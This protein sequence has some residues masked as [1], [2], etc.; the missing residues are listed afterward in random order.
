MAATAETLPAA[1]RDEAPYTIRPITVDEYHRMLEVGILYEKEPVEL[2]DG[3]L[4]A[5]PP[6]GPAHA[7]VFSA[8]NALFVHTFGDRALVRPGGP[9]ELNRISEPEPDLAL[10]RRTEDQYF[11]SHPKPEDVL[12][13]V[14][15]SHSS[16]AYD[17]RQKLSAYARAGIAEYW[18]VDLVHRRIEIFAEPQND[19]YEAH[20]TARPGDSIAPRAFPNDALSVASL[21]P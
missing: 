13:L 14:E 12:L 21:L 17:R 15:V 18:I 7:S 8:L 10:V 19:R 4:I 9:I 16:L 6:Q 1:A 2:L 3:Q 5:M 11:G 20:Q